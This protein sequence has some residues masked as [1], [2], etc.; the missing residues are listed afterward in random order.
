MLGPFAEHRGIRRAAYSD[1]PQRSGISA[2]EPHRSC[3][4]ERRRVFPLY[5][6]I[7]SCHG[8]R[9]Y[10]RPAW[11]RIHKGAHRASTQRISNNMTTRDQGGVYQGLQRR[12][13]D[14]APTIQPPSSLGGRAV[15]RIV[16]QVSKVSHSIIQENGFPI[17]KD[18]YPGSLRYAQPRPRVSSNIDK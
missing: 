5:P 17:V 15:I 12:T 8:V 9:R 2:S 10:V 7:V 11:D 6:T 4:L 18:T 1:E 3:R 16:G 13:R 14:P